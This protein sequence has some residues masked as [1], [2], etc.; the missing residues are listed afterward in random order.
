MLYIYRD[1][2]VNESVTKVKTNIKISKKITDFQTF[3]IKLTVY[4]N[5]SELYLEMT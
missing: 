2:H 3:I 4:K 1:K 5:C